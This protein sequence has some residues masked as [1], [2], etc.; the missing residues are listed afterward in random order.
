[1]TIS[2]TRAHLKRDCKRREKPERFRTMGPLTQDL[3]FFGVV[4]F[5]W[6]T[7]QTEELFDLISSSGEKL[8]VSRSLF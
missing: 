1:M 5:I 8:N 2:P 6:V 3:K 7:P 4:E